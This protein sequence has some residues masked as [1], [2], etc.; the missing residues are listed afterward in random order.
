MA[1]VIT[2]EGEVNDIGAKPGLKKLQ[3]AVGGYIERVA[4]QDVVVYVNEEGMLQNLPI[5]APF[6]YTTGMPLHGNVVVMEEG[7]EE[8]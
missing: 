2:T 6:L 1:Y 3:E 7:D 8:E 5:N 4:L